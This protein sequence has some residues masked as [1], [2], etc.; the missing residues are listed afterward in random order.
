LEKFREDF[1]TGYDAIIAEFSSDMKL[2]HEKVDKLADDLAKKYKTI[3]EVDFPK[4]IKATKQL[5]EKY[6][7]YMVSTHVETGELIF[8]VLDMGIN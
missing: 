5:V 6:G 4:S 8:V 2:V 7:Q 1:Q 3:I